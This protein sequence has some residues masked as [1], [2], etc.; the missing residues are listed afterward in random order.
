MVESNQNL[1]VIYEATLDSRF[2]LE[3]T[4]NEI[5]GGTIRLYDTK[6]EYEL[7]FKKDVD[8]LYGA[9]FGPD[10]ADVNYWQDLVVKYVDQDK[11]C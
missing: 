7:L 2:K 10:V 8:L 6:K 11:E 5:G 9:R 4:R 3:V 1:E